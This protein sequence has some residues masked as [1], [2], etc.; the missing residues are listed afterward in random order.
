MAGELVG[1]ALLAVAVVAVAW[2]ILAAVVYRID[3]PW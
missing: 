2:F 1:G 3:R